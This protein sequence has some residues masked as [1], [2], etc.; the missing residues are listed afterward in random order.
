MTSSESV[1]LTNLTTEGVFTSAEL[2]DMLLNPERRRDYLRVG[3]ERLG[4]RQAPTPSA[5]QTPSPTVPVNRTPFTIPLVD[6][7]FVFHGRGW[8]HGVGLSQWGAH[9]LAMAGWRADRILQHYYPGTMIKRF[10]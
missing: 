3:L 10:M 1:R 7:H 8:G 6:G 4:E 9:A 5:P 2:L